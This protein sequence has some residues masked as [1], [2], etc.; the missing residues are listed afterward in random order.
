MAVVGEAVE[1]LVGGLV[2]DEGLGVV[3]PVGDPGADRGDESRTERWVPRLSHLV[4]S[5]ANQRST[6]FSQRAVGRR[7]VER[8][9]GV[10][11]QP[12]LDR[13]GLVGRRVVQHDVDVE[14]RRARSCRSGSRTGGTPR[15]GAAAVM[16]AITLPGGDVER[17]V[18]VGGAV[19]LV[20]VG[21]PLGRPGISGRIGA[22][23]SSAW[24]WVFSSTHST[25]AASGG[26]RYRPTMSRTLSMNS[27]SG[28]SL[29]VSIRCGLSPNARQIRTDR[30][31]A[32][33]RSPRPS[34]AS[35]SASR[36]PAVSSA[37]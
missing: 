23:R 2:P 32:T 26:F 12:A 19:A 10:A 20:V 27:G 17:G 36:R 3:V 35:T 1:D 14:V 18:E 8:E 31:L 7:E 6:R 29:N 11:E 5:S 15:P 21:A 34:T 22:V 33:S 37:S 16:S 4:V 24:I 9:A 13:R 28:D 25:T 30:R